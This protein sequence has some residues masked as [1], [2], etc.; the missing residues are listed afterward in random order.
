MVLSFFDVIVTIDDA[1]YELVLSRLSRIADTKLIQHPTWMK[2]LASISYE[3]LRR[4]FKDE[5]VINVS[6]LFL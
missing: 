5:S 1:M 2:K 6:I 4:L 3:N